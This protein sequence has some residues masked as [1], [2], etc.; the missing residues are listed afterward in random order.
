MIQNI[1]TGGVYIEADGCFSVGQE[2][3]ISYLASN[4]RDQIEV[5]GEVVRTDRDGFAM[6]Y[7]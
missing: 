6:R 3:S 7:L 4:N 1:S 5:Q 2:I